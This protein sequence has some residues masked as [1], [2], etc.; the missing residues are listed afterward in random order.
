MRD[1]LCDQM[2]IL[3]FSQTTVT[4]RLTSNMDRDKNKTLLEE[5]I[6]SKTGQLELRG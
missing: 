6:A 5:V 3:E 1:R 4:N 2:Q